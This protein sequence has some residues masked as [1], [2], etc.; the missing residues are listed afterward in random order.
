MG[1]LHGRQRPS[2]TSL[3]VARANESF[4]WNHTPH[5]IGVSQ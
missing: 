2:I 4:R 1:G 5:A 3:A